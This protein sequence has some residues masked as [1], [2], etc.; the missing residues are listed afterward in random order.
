MPANPLARSS[1]PLYDALA[2]DYDEHFAVPHRRAY[3]EL[4]WQAVVEQLPA[5]RADRPVVDAGCGVGRWAQRLIELGHRVVGIEQAPR[6][7]AGARARGLGERFELIESPMEDVELPA[8]SV[9]AVVAMGSLQY[10]PDPGAVLGA[11]ARWV[12]PGGVVAVLVD[13]LEAL[14]AELEAAGRAEEAA[15]RR[16]TRRGLWTAE[17]HAA[18]LHLFDAATLAATMRAAGL[19]Q[20]EVRG[21]LCGW[22]ELGRDA[23]MEELSTAPDRAMAR[24][25]EWSRDPAMADRGKQLLGLGR[26]PAR[27]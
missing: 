13:G 22:T 3:D 17:G 27:D 15:E 7:S 1:V 20:V 9:A 23:L 4:S 25:A 5:P 11:F 26:V 19:D 12:A 2:G 21:V 10:T 16:R 18:D 24:E 8:G 6:M 14:V